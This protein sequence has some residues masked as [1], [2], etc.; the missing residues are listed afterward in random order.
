VGRRA[1]QAPGEGERERLLPPL[2][3]ERPRAGCA[4]APPLVL[5]PQLRDVPE[6]EAGAGAA[7]AAAGAGRGGAAAGA[8][9]AAGHAAAAGARCA[10]AA[11]AV[12]AAAAADTIAAAGMAG[13]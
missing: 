10:A 7:A 3:G 9:A 13:V 5:L 4:A 12:A 2:P 1:P 11:A 8:G 6:E